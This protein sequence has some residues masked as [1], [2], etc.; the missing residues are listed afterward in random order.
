MSPGAELPSGDDERDDELLLELLQRLDARPC[1]APEMLEGAVAGTLSLAEA[2]DVHAHLQQCAACLSVFARL[3]SLQETSID[4]VSPPAPLPELLTGL[5]PAVTTLRDTVLRVLGSAAS[6]HRPPTILLEGET[7]T[8]KSFLA[9]AIHRVGPRADGPFVALN[10]SAIPEELL[11]AELFGYERGAFSGAH[12][13]KPGLLQTANRGTMFLD[14]VGLLP[15]GLQAKF[16]KALESGT[17]FRLG[18]TRAEPIDVWLMT[19]TTSDLMTAIQRRQFREDFYHR[20]AR[21]A[22]RLP[23]LRERGEDVLMLAD[24]YLGRLCAEYGVPTKTLAADAK[25]AL[26]A[27][28]WPGNIREL[29]SVI[30]RAVILSSERV[31]TASMLHLSDDPA[32]EEVRS[33]NRVLRLDLSP[34]ER[35]DRLTRDQLTAALE[36]A[37]GNLIRAAALLG[38]APTALRQRL[39]RLGLLPEEP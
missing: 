24:R 1:L 12:V 29:V 8:G 23:P 20:I 30:E 37:E 18:G 32:E 10:C 17:V 14:E 19:A 28:S 4:V 7:G 13:S 27:Y 22:F 5:S 34:R 3:Q 16:L 6:S 25:A 31:L 39:K 15:A 33:V 38:I 35:A 36:E 2:A 9:R 21:V 26:I 11:E